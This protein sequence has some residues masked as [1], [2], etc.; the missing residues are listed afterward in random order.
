MTF[1]DAVTVLESY[2]TMKAE[3][4]TFRE[5]LQGI[6]ANVRT[7]DQSR[8]LASTM[9]PSDPTQ[10]AVIQREDLIRKMERCAD[11]LYLIDQCIRAVP[12]IRQ[13][14]ILQLVYID[15]MTRQEAAD[16]MKLRINFLSQYHNEGVRQFAEI[17]EK[18]QPE[19][20]QDSEES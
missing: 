11:A 16:Y 5:Q 10:R 3:L 20:G 13:R 6:A 18:M 7:V 2:Q 12:N 17:F 19:A 8:F 1:E 14:F 9:Q 15:G 4:A